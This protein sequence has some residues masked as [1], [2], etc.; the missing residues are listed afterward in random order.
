MQ[1]FIILFANPETKR[2]L[3]TFIAQLLVSPRGVLN[4]DRPVCVCEARRV[5]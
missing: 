3:S 5:G 2:P 1:F 4:I